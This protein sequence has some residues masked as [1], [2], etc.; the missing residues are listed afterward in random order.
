MNNKVIVKQS[1]RS[2]NSNNSNSTLTNEKHQFSP[3]FPLTNVNS[4]NK[5]ENSDKQN[6]N[7]KENMSKIFISYFNR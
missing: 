1:V 4:N 3:T 5:A 7:K 2:N 6:S